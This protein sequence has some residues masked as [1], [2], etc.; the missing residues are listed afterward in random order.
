MLACTG[1][2]SLAEQFVVPKHVDVVSMVQPAIF[3]PVAS[4][5]AN[6]ASQWKTRRCILGPPHQSVLSAWVYP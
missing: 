4:A 5:Q 3:S 1:A 2:M 6:P